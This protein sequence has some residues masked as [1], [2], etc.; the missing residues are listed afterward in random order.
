M[1]SLPRV[2][3]ISFL[4]AV[5]GASS[6]LG[7]AKYPKPPDEYSV[8]FRYRI[9]ADRNE[10]VR[11]FEEMTKNLGMLGFKETETDDSDLAMFDPSA[12]RMI[13]TIPSKTAREILRDPR[14]KT[15]LIVPSGFTPPADEKDRV[16][17]ALDIHSGFGLETQRLFS[18]QTRQILENFGFRDDVGY[19]RRNYSLL[20]GTIPWINVKML[21]KDLRTQ[22]TG[23]FLPL[24][25]IDDLPEPYKTVL[26]IRLIEVMPEEGAPAPVAMQ[27]PLPPIPAEQ[28]QLAKL[29]ADLRRRL[30]QEGKKDEK[31]R[32]ELVLVESP[33]EAD[34]SWRE[35]II[36]ANPTTSIEGRLGNV[37]TIEVLA[38][39]QAVQIARLPIVLSVRLPCSASASP[40]ESSKKDQPKKD[41]PNEKTAYHDLVQVQVLTPPID[42]LK[43]TRLDRLHARGLRGAG[44]RVAIIDTDFNGY[45][46]FVGKELPRSTTYVDLTAERNREIQPE[47]GETAPG[48]LGHGTQLALAVRFAAPDADIALVRVAGD[49]PYQIV[50]AYRFMLGDFTQPESF[51]VR[52]EE[53]ESDVASVRVERARA[54]DQYRKAFDDFDDDE[55]ARLRRREAKLAI[56]VVEEK[57]RNLTARANRLL[58]LEQDLVRLNGCKIILNNLGW[59]AGQPL[60]G[61][62]AISRFL[63]RKMLVPRTNP[64]RNSAKRPHPTLWFQPAGDTRGQSWTGL[65]R[66]ADGNGVMEFAAPGTPLRPGRWT[67]ELNFLAF[68]TDSPEDVLDLPMNARVRITVQWREAHDRDVAEDVYREPIAPLNMMLL[69]QRDPNAEKA[70]SDEMEPIAQSEGL[71]ERLWVEREFGIYEQSLDVMLPAGGRYALRVEGKVPL[72]TRPGGSL[73]IADQ[74]VHWELRPRLFIEVLDAPTK[75]KGR[76]VFSDYVSHLGGV[77]VPADAQSAIAVGAMHATRKP[78]PFSAI[79]AGPNS[80]LQVK[81]DVM[82]YDRLPNLGGGPAQGSA[83]S[84]ALAT[85]VGTSLLSGGAQPAYFMQYL[86]IPPGHVFVVPDSWIKK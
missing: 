54:N 77:A 33:G 15:V 75:A 21:L 31:L 84:A 29:T 49:A 83:F 47:P 37:I 68:R 38:G 80:E 66:D 65:F 50:S 69:R 78:E 23:W 20:R 6:S 55:P 85:G 43:E 17:V 27:Q 48:V 39:D 59:N 72:G 81:P 63:D 45:E 1:N 10:R 79:G 52:R 2:L 64:V 67:P 22:P 3:G 32:V 41:E 9:Q 16:K 25:H 70:P 46:K 61:A 24:T 4:V 36:R 71:A 34:N 28:P 18:Q 86:R 53:L 12:E 62:S 44:Q 58:K 5:V 19:D 57:E 14:I 74:A 13:G 11:Q 40:N 76:I 7:Q 51:R 30:L 73:G 42:V 56:A 60:D 8:Q 35:A 82:T 26:P